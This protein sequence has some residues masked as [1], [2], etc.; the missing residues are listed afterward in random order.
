MRLYLDSADQTQW[1][2]WLP[3]GLFAGMTTNPTLL[4]RARVI[5]SIE[6]LQTLAHRSFDLG[7]KE[8]HLQ[9]WGEDIERLVRTG[10][11]LAAIDERV[12]VKVPITHSGTGAAAQLIAR[13]IRVTLTGVY[14]RHQALIA[15][16]VG[17]NYAA[18][19]LGRI[20]DLTNKGREELVAMQQA[21]DGVG[22]TTRLL[23]ASIRSVD[24]VAFLATHGLN[25][26]TISADI[27][28][29]LF[30]VTATNESAAAFEQAALRIRA[31]P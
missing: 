1:Q 15:A 24:D 16:A 9:A 29:A 19:Y 14:A 3:V 22:S 27:A 17:A 6:Q 18:P 7:V 10:T 2:A 8:L 23:V 11:A 5:C 20:D 28:T 26:F 30:D 4:E 12:V 31:E 21:L 13:G 25:T